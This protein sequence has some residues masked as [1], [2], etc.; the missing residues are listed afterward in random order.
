VF[1][2]APL[3]EMSKDTKFEYFLITRST[4]CG[5][6]KPS[7]VSFTCNTIFVPTGTSCAHSEM[8]KLP[9]PSDSHT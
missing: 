9:V 7:S 3:S 2:F 8:V 6:Q 1:S 4:T 5:V